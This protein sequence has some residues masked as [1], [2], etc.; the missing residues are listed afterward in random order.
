MIGVWGLSACSLGW[1]ATDFTTTYNDPIP[2]KAKRAEP[3]MHHPDVVEYP[4]AYRQNDELKAGFAGGNMINLRAKPSTKSSI[5][6][7]LPLG[8]PIT[9]HN[10]EKQATQGLR[11]DHWYR[12][13][14]TV[15]GKQVE[16]YL[17]GPTINPHRI[18]ADFDLD[19]EL[20]AIYASYNER[21]EMLIHYHNPNGD[22]PLSWTKI[23]QFANAH[24]TSSAAILKIIPKETAG[25][26]LL[27]IEVDCSENCGGSVWTK[28]LSFSNT[29]IRRALDI[30][31]NENKN[32]RINVFFHPQSKS[33]SLSSTEQSLVQTR[34]Y[35]LKNG[36]YRFNTPLVENSQTPIKK[37]DTEEG[38]PTASTEV[39]RPKDDDIRP[40]KD[41]KS[42]PL[43]ANK[44]V[45]ATNP[46]PKDKAVHTEDH[47]TER[48]PQKIAPL[49]KKSMAEKRSLEPKEPAQ[50]TEK[51]K[52]VDTDKKPVA[53]A[54]SES[55][56]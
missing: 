12:V 56:R 41:R 34:K 46:K 51:E 28:Y 52:T 49:A 35:T 26:P 5:V 14:A 4:I 45:K 55:E 2:V 30:E 17:F 18:A 8:A 3:P 19:G 13:S 33:I 47:Q 15:R 50:I 22:S 11:Q 29:G 32:A 37:E 43:T 25:I 40:V 23:G 42:Q 36:I 6:S 10:Q 21:K 9:V 1:L 54:S 48:E 53:K 7:K 38:K 24:G 39:N 27:K 20:E 31:E 44:P 16:G